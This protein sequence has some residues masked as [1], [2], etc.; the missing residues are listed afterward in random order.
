M[1]INKRINKARSEH[2]EEPDD[3]VSSTETRKDEK[4]HGDP[5]SSTERTT[6]QEDDDNGVEYSGWNYTHWN[7]ADAKVVLSHFDAFI[8]GKTKKKLSGKEK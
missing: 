2:E 3:L 5:V 7:D 6:T 8:Q 1:C 4:Q